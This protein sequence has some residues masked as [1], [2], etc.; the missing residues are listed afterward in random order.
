ML[1]GTGRGPDTARQGAR[2]SPPLSPSH[3][4]SA[5]TRSSGGSTEVPEVRL[6]TATFSSG[7][8]KQIQEQRSGVARGQTLARGCGGG[9]RNDPTFVFKTG[10]IF[11]FLHRHTSL[12]GHLGKLGPER[13]IVFKTIC[14]EKTFLQNLI[15]NNLIFKM[16]QR[17]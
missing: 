1:E 3:C 7:Y 5:G 17:P 12:L 15:I 6:K 9:R 4:A 2:A 14:H 10:T 8:F 13:T 11:H 16:G